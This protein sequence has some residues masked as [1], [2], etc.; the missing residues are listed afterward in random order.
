MN[1]DTPIIRVTKEE[2]NALEGSHAELRCIVKASPTPRIHW[3]RNGRVVHNSEKF[4][5]HVHPHEKHHHN[6]TTLKIHD[7]NKDDLG[8]YK[9]HAEN[10]LGKADATVTLVYE[11]EVATL[12]ECRLTDDDLHTVM[13]NWTV[14]SAQPVSEAVI[15]YKQNGERSWQQEAMKSTIVKLEDN[16]WE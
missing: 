2:V 10:T 13:C 11:P 14:H 1:L 12:N 3:T 7:V 9:C 8:Q 6:M 5:S 4:R 15:S 16:K